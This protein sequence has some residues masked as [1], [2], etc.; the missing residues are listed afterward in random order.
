MSQMNKDQL[1]SIVE[2]I[3]KLN[4]EAAAI[5][6]DIKDVYHEARSQ[7]FEVKYI[8]KCIELRKK[9]A[10]EVYEEDELLRMYREALGI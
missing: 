1:L 6:A 5:A 7:G 8:R 4:D 10:D 9:G 3:E 2:R